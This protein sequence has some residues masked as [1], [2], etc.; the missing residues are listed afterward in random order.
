MFFCQLSKT[1]LTSLS[2]LLVAR[3][4]D[5][6]AF[7]WEIQPRLGY[8]TIAFNNSTETQE[9]VFLYD[10][11]LLN[12]N[13]S[14]RVTVFEDDCKTIGSDAITHLDD[15]SVDHELA[16]LVDVDQETISISTYY[17]SINMTNAEISFCLRGM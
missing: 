4:A 3:L 5:G 10:A 9:I 12:D 1:L 15:A 7:D 6:K 8:P 13:K 14:Y 2:A 16:V 17:T 11:P